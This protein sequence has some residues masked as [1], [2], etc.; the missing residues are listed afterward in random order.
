MVVVQ[1]FVGT[2][3][4]DLLSLLWEGVKTLRLGM[5]MV[6]EDQ[7]VGI[8]RMGSLGLGSGSE[9]GTSLPSKTTSL[10]AVLVGRVGMA[11][12]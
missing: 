6:T 3:V 11:G 4:S 2:G 9:S 8:G 10:P 5:V 12:S 7:R 1:E